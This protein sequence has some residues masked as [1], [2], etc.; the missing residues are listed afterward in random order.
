MSMP[1][2]SNEHNECLVDE[3][4]LIKS[5][6]F[7]D[8][9][10]NLADRCIRYVHE[11]TFQNFT[12]L[13]VLVLSNNLIRVIPT[14]L[15]QTSA[16]LTHLWLNDNRIVTINSNTFLNCTN[17]IKVWLNNNQID[18]LD[19]LNPFRSCKRL[20]C[21]DLSGNP[22][23][24]CKTIHP[25]KFSEC[26]NLTELVLFGNSIPNPNNYNFDDDYNSNKEEQDENNDFEMQC[27]SSL[28]KCETILENTSLDEEEAKQTNK[29]IKT[30]T[31]EDL[32]LSI[33]KIDKAKL[34]FEN[35]CRICEEEEIS[36]TFM[37]CKHAICCSEC[38][39]RL[40]RCI[41]CQS[42]IIDKM[43]AEAN[44]VNR[45]INNFKP[46]NEISSLVNKMKA[47][48]EAQTCSI[49]LERKKDIVFN[50]GHS[51]CET[52][53]RMLKKCQIC[54]RKIEIRIKTYA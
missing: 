46:I 53:S 2:N 41:E 29:Q 32:Q 33:A 8:L 12:N 6:K 28:R 34:D 45:E 30:D 19:H 49:C 22:I 40:K 20:K 25:K 37:P 31:N 9:F 48:E 44:K 11:S 15:F 5:C 13:T 10:I 1:M 7:D 24:N 26:P 51:A 36:L 52:C 18:A 14:H 4:Y 38:G 42:I 47:Y 43:I 16:N 54:R 21:L 35:K 50:C 23:A 3:N 27:S 39:I 17:L